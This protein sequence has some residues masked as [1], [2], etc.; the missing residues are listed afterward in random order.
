[1]SEP[2]AGGDT[3]SH[4]AGV[5]PPDLEE[6]LTTAGGDNFE[7]RPIRPGDADALVAFHQ[8]LSPDSIYLRYFSFHPVLSAAEVEHLTRVDYV[9]RFAF[10]IEGAD[11]LVGVGRYDRFP[12]TSTAEVAFIVRDAYQRRGLGQALLTR[13]AA[14]ARERGV[15][16]F[17]AETMAA[18]RDMM[19]VFRESGYPV[20]AVLDDETYRVEIAIAPPCA[21]P[22]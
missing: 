5:Y 6:Q 13:L 15:R 11:G 7:L 4:P 2:D 10:V 22:S 19:N 9:N 12:G 16:T 8:R 1:V 17:V 18:N 20:T 3:G 21:E 14:A